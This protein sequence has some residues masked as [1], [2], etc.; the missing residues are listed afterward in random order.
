[1]RQKA[2]AALA[3]GYSAIVD[4]VSLRPAERAALAEVARRAGVPFSGLWL[5][6]APETMAERIR[7]RRHDASD[8]T[9]AVLARQLEHDPGPIDWTCL[10][11]G[12]GPETT[13]AAAHRA[14]ALGGP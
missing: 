3:A 6:A 11:A 8:A 7:I 1:L 13:L 14:L 5:E 4:A 2:A 10:D 9:A 12:G